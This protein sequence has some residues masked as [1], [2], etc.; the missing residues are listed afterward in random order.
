MYNSSSGSEGGVTLV[1]LRRDV[2]DRVPVSFGV[3]D[4]DFEQEGSE[5]EVEQVGSFFFRQVVAKT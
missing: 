2:F 4:A 1:E 5:V 3:V